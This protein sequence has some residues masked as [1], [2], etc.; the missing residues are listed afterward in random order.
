MLESHLPESDRPCGHTVRG[1]GAAVNCF[2]DRACVFLRVGIVRLRPN[3]EYFSK[4]TPML[5]FFVAKIPGRFSGTYHDQ[6][7]WS[8][9]CQ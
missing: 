1:Y 6:M 2:E 3:L 8:V 7:S 5:T 4:A 9:K